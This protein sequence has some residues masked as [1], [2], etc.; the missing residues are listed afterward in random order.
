MFTEFLLE[1][2][3]WTDVFHLIVSD[4]LAVGGLSLYVRR[5]VSS[6]RDFRRLPS[7]SYRHKLLLLTE[8]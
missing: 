8:K 5:F 6:L 3:D 1:P 7:S 4:Q 2:D